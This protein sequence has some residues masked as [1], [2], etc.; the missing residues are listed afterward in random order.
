MELSSYELYDFGE[1]DAA[2]TD[3]CQIESELSLALSSMADIG[4]NYKGWDKSRLKEFLDNYNMGENSIVDSIYTLVVEDPAN[5]L[6]YYVSYLEFWNLRCKAKTEKRTFTSREFHKVIL[7]CGPAPF[8][9][10]EKQVDKYLL[11][12]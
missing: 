6:Q 7:D 8:T 1:D 11:K 9:V 5:Y 12:T 2:L 10:L 4:V 3:L